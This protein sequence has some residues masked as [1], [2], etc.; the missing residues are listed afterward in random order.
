[1]GENDHCSKIVTL[2]L[3]ESRYITEYLLLSHI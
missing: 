2:F 1:M 3:E